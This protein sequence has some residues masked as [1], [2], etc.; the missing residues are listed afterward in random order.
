[1]NK[2]SMAMIHQRGKKLPALYDKWLLLAV[3]SLMALGLMMVASSSIT[4]SYKMFN[5]PFHFLIKQAVYLLV[6]LGVAFAVLRIEINAWKKISAQLLIISFILLVLVLI[7]GIGRQING[8]MRWI[9]VGPIGMQ[10]SELVKLFMIIYIAGYLVR[11]GDEVRQQV[12]GFIKPMLVLGILSLLLLKQP[13]FG[14]AVVIIVTALGMMFLAGVR[15]WQ[16]VVLI[17]LVAL[18]LAA[19]A[20]A[21][22]YRM[23]RL[24]AFINPWAHPFQ[25]GYQLTQSLIAFGR[26]GWQGVGLGESVQKLFYLPEAHTDFIFAVLAE[27]LGLI[28]MLVTIALFVLLVFRCFAVGKKAQ[29][30]EKNFAAFVAYGIGFWIALQMLI[31][32]GVNSGILPTKGLTLPLI[33][34]G[35]SSLIVMCITLAILIRIDYENRLTHY[36]LTKKRRA[37]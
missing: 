25:D 14:A 31:N 5:T 24:T 36:G 26:G 4:I 16:Y 23:H 3:L 2:K 8:S 15:L 22:P 28:G 6:G 1:M 7:P 27:E 12:S 34:Y 20:I 37:R 33:S 30:L 17:A 10:I 21:S 11:R 32:I 29:L 19:I 18:A 13:D 9:G 35:G